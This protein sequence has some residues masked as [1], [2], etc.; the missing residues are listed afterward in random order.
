MNEYGQRCRPHRRESMDTDLE[1][2]KRRLIE[3][4]FS[5]SI[6][7]QGNILFESRSKGLKDLF[8]AVKRLDTSLRNAS[9]AD[10]I[11]GKA[12]AFLFVYSRVNSVFAATIS[13]KGFEV[14]EQNHL[15]AEYWNIIPDVLNQERTDV[16][17]FEKMVMDC[18]DAK[19]AFGILR[20]VFG[21]ME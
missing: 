18:R 10:Q 6:V 12:A 8:E 3:N 14:L 4:R 17:P 21:Q 11:V 1:I 9:V 19:R 5:L 20:K 15:F 16:C 7:K 2:A 13:E